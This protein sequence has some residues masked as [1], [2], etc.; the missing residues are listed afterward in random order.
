ME[1]ED[2]AGSGLGVQQIREVRLLAGG[3][4]EER[5]RAPVG[6]EVAWEALAVSLGLSLDTAE[7]PPLLLGLDRPRDGAV[8]VEDVVNGPGLEGELTHG[9]AWASLDIGRAAILD[10]PARCFELTVDLLPSFLFRAPHP[11]KGSP[12]GGGSAQFVFEPG[13]VVVEVIGTRRMNPAVGVIRGVQLKRFV[14]TRASGP[15][16]VDI[17]FRH[18]HEC[19]RLPPS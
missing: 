7:G 18:P 3:L 14:A 5:K 13:G 8:D 1:R 16:V 12:S 15:A 11:K 17:E 6:R 9:D 4:I 19:P 2:G 10:E